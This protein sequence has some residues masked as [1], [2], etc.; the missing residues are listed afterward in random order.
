MR[1][2]PEV[3]RWVA[4]IDLDCTFTTTVNIVEL[5]SGI[6]EQ[7][8]ATDAERLQFWLDNTVKPWFAGRTIEIGESTLLRWLVLMKQYQKKQ[9][10]VPAVD[11]LIAAAALE[12]NLSVATRDVKPFVYVGVPVLNPWTGERFNGA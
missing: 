3:G 1:P 11:L 7:D 8:S 12:E 6:L 5:Q 2:S 10:G 4:S 9:G